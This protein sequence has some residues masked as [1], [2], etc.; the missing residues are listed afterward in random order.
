MKLLLTITSVLTTALHRLRANMGLALCALLALVAAVALAM[1]VP[2]YAEGASLRLLRD[3]IIRQERQTGRS[4]FA[5]LFRYVSSQRG[6]LEWDRV[7]PADSYLSGDGLNSLGLERESFARH[8]RTDQLR[9]FLPPR[10]G[11]QNQFLRTVALGFIGGLDAQIHI[12]DGAAPQPLASPPTEQQP[13]EVLVSRSLA[14]QVGINVDDR[15]TLVAA[16]SRPASLPIRIAGLWEPANANDPA[17]FF[18]PETLNEVFLTAEASFTGPVAASLKGE[19]AQVL[20]YARL[21]GRGLSA[22]QAGPLLSRVEALRA[23]AAGLV[24]GL[25]LEISPADPL[26][27]YQKRAT[28]LTIQLGVFSVPILG[29]V[30]YFAAL[31]AG[32]LV[33]RQRGEIAL[34]KTRGVRDSQIL[35]I[36][37][38]EW[39]ILGGLAMLIGPPLGLWF[40]ALMGRTTSFLQLDDAA[41]PLALA[42]TGD[43]LRFGVAAVVLALVAALIPVTAATRRTLVDEQQQAARQLRPPFWQ[44][45]YLDLLLLI[46]PVY[47]IYQLQRSGGIQVGTLAGADPFANP[48]LVL[49]PLLLCFALGLLAVRLIPVL[50]ELLARLSTRPNWVAPLV[51][52]RSLARQPA[53]YRGPL[54][55]LILTMS[56]ATWSASMAT[57]IEGSIRQAISYQVGA[58]TRLIEAGETAARN[59]NPGQSPGPRPQP[60]PAPSADGQQEPRFLFVPVRDH[61][62]VVGI[63]AATRVGIYEASL[64]SGGSAKDGQLIGIDRLDFPK[65]IP[66]FKRTWA[67]GE[68]L[69]ALMNVLARYPDG[70]IVSRNALTG[71]LKI[72]DRL[73]LQLKLAGDQRAATL[74][75]VA[76][77]DL[78]PGFYPQDGPIIITNLDY[79]FD[80]MGGQYP[81]DVWIARDPASD[82]DVLVG[83]VRKLGINVLDQI[84]AA[85]LTIREQTAPRRQGLFGLLSVGFITAAIL[86]LLGFLLSVLISARRRA[87]ELGVLQAI[88]LGAGQ[89]AIAL[90]IELALVV[91]A[92]TGAGTGIGLV[93]A[94]LVVPLLQVGT[95]P[96]PGTPAYGAQI[97]WDEVT[98]IYAVF[99]TTLLLTL[100]ALG[101][102]LART[103]LNQAVKLGDAN[104]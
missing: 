45:Y 50:L 48:L 38:I 42:I 34:L 30:L 11:G 88:G 27:R 79:L 69:G 90:I 46:P 49:V 31:V 54:L 87:I 89:V 10:S 29:L 102:I 82:L 8:A 67:S 63:T 51:A 77:V 95:G 92:G 65:V 36:S 78:F 21:S 6:P 84:D 98:I 68:S 58:Q 85:D 71:G 53:A 47:G 94:L 55:L 12:Y 1:C 26:D 56:L 25:R 22:A 80:Q 74:R 81:Y 99:A 43:T 64:Q 13:L 3:E 83:G 44:R 100:L 60:T 59:Q 2:I 70:A 24:P 28:E 73:P 40:A 104:L 39:L 76:I 61:L 7:Q 35:G 17:W 57:T 41:E 20:W 18:A 86:T 97:A 4:P 62:S 33:V 19:V 9:L 16:G 101:M 66:Q 32:M 72:G 5:L 75:I 93:A 91:L 52:L 15:F 23:R 103:Q 14:D 96:Y 37:L